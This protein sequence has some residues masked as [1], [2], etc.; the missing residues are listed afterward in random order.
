MNV[1]A[2]AGPDVRHLAMGAAVDVFAA[3]DVVA[4]REQLQQGVQRGEPGAEGEPVTPAF[5]R[6]DV[7]LQ[8]LARGIAGAG[9]LV[10]F[11]AARAR[12]GCTWRSGKSGVMTAP[13]RGSSMV[14]GVHRAGGKATIEV[15]P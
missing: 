11:V 15:L 8:R 10:A 14:P 6:R 7:A 13:A 4:R 5:E 3:D 1:Q 12:P 2:V 9:V